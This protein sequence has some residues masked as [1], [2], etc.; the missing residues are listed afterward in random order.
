ML[1]RSY[2]DF[3]ELRAC[4][5]R[6]IPI[7]RTPVNKGSS[8]ALDFA[9]W[10]HAYRWK[11]MALRPRRGKGAADGVSADIAP[12]AAHRDARRSG[13]SHDR[14]PAHRPIRAA[15][16]LPC[17]PSSPAATLRPYGGGHLGAPRGGGRCGGLG[18]TRGG[19]LVLGRLRRP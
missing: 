9:K 2:A 12:P 19:V 8:A 13:F 16:R 6:R 5:L 3:R 15:S 18:G 10:H 14:P 7:P 17:P 11:G 4:E 1:G